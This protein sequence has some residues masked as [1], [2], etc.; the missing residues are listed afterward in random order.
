MSN[1]HESFRRR[2]R[3]WLRAAPMTG[4][5]IFPRWVACKRRDRRIT[6][7]PHLHA[8]IARYLL[9]RDPQALAEL[10]AQPEDPG[11]W[12]YWVVSL[13]VTLFTSG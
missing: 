5:R 9:R 11:Q 8:R 12:A 13:I 7:M 4:M 2:V 10:L 3:S 6:D 1:F